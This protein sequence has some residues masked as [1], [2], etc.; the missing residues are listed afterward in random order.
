MFHICHMLEHMDWSIF[1]FSKANG[2]VR[3][4][5]ISHIRV[6]LGCHITGEFIKLNPPDT[7]TKC[8]ILVN[9][10]PL[11][12]NPDMSFQYVSMFCVDW[13]EL[14]EVSNGSSCLIEH[15]NGHIKI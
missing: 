13:L 4:T 12:L 14:E 5:V 11:T 6:W 2:I 3:W 1:V 10:E 9:M 8:I 15:M 7:W